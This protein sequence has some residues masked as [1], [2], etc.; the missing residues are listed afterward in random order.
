MEK[1]IIINTKQF[2]YH[3]DSYKYA[4]Y[5]KKKWD[6]TYICFDTGHK[7]IIEQDVNVIYIDW[8]GSFIR[9]LFTFIIKSIKLIK[10]NNPN[11]VFI[12]HFE[13]C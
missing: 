8:I 6:V 11:I 1:I 2:G 4:K 12:V 5:L 13:F 9:K 7:K 10:N 3:I